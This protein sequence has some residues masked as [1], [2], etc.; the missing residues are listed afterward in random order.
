MYNWFLKMGSGDQ[1]ESVV[2]GSRAKGGIEYFK[3]LLH[4]RKMAQGKG[5]AVLIA[6]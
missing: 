1:L 3:D 2:R 6:F 4:F 5:L